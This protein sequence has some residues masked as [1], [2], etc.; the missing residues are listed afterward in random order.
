MGRGREERRRDEP[1]GER[2]VWDEGGAEKTDIRPVSRAGEG[3]SDWGSHCLPFFLPPLTGRALLPP[4]EGG[5]RGQPGRL[6][7][8]HQKEEN[9]KYWPMTMI[10]VRESIGKQ[11]LY[12]SPGLCSLLSEGSS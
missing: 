1:G 4:E 5:D 6:L 8:Q 9:R 10:G 11:S 2:R 3:Q 12:P 7:R